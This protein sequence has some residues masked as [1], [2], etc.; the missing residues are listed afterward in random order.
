MIMEAIIQTTISSTGLKNRALITLTRHQRILHGLN[1]YV[2]GLVLN[3]YLISSLMPEFFIAHRTM[4][5]S[6]LIFDMVD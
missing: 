6:H 1:V 5:D 3:F 4:R 2:F